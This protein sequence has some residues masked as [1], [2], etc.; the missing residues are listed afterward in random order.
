MNDH[1]DPGPSSALAVTISWGTVFT[2]WGLAVLVCGGLGYLHPMAGAML[3]LC[4]GIIALLL[5]ARTTQQII[6]LQL[7][8]RDQT[9]HWRA[10]AMYGGAFVLGLASALVTG[11]AF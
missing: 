4:P 1:I 6:R 5:G 10:L 9:V 3:A 11:L 2:F 7:E 8:R